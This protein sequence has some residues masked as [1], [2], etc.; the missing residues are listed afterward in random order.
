MIHSARFTVLRASSV[1][2]SQLKSVLL[3]LILKRV[4]GYTDGRTDTTCENSDHYL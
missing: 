1:H 3:Y 2:F 4:D